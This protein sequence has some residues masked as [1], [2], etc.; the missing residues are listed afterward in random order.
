MEKGEGIEGE[1]CLPWT[2]TTSGWTWAQRAWE[3]VEVS[4]ARKYFL[5]GWEVNPVG[6]QEEYLSRIKRS[7][8]SQPGYRDNYSL[9]IDYSCK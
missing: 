7:G 4:W 2:H 5:V 1:Y 9:F 3:P 8:A 6:S